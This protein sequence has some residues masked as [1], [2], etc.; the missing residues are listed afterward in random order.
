M[1][2]Y[3]YDLEGIDLED[4]SKLVLLPLHVGMVPAVMGTLEALTWRSRHESDASH[5]IGIDAYAEMQE[6]FDVNDCITDLLDQ[7]IDALT[8]LQCI[9][10]Q[11]QLDQQFN[12]TALTEN[13]YNNL[14]GD[15]NVSYT[16]DEETNYE[17]GDP[18]TGQDQERCQRTQAVFYNLADIADRVVNLQLGVAGVS[19][20]AMAGLI[21]GFLTVP[22]PVSIVIGLIVGIT[23]VFIE[24]SI[25]NDLATWR[26]L[27]QEAI[28]TIYNA[29]DMVGASAGIHAMIDANLATVAGKTYLKLFY[30]STLMGQM[31]Q[32]ADNWA[33]FD[34]AACDECIP[35]DPECIILDCDPAKWN[36]FGNPSWLGCEGGKPYCAGGYIRSLAGSL[37]VPAGDYT[38]EIE[39]TAKGDSGNAWF[40]V[41]LFFTSDNYQVNI[42]DSQPLA[43]G[44]SRTEKWHLY[45]PRPDGDEYEI[46]LVQATWYGVVSGW[47]IRPGHV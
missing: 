47:C 46:Q 2:V 43:V 1:R 17:I 29:S 44:T 12:N 24:D 6:V 40:G 27:A 35:G 31:W 22:I 10:T 5:Q 3:R 41:D 11:S 32:N 30:S 21:A 38:L 45:N 34:G 7:M 37:P 26:G 42:P 39:W 23:Y 16:G 14:E 33:S 9:C 20:G 15:T 13:I 4:C 18:P 28:C 25:Q 19:A 36:T 8:A